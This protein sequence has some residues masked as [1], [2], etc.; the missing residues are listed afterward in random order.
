[1]SDVHVGMQVAELRDTAY[2]ALACMIYRCSYISKDL[3][4]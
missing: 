4:K 3:A 1:M 2:I